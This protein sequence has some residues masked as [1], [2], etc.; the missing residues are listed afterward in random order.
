ML[1]FI[2]SLIM[3]AS[4]VGKLFEIYQKASN[5]YLLAFLL[6]KSSFAN[7]SYHNVLP[8]KKVKS[9]EDDTNDDVTAEEEKFPSS[10]TSL[11]MTNELTN[12]AQ[13]TEIVDRRLRL[14]VSVAKS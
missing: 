7:R 8:E 6:T 11:V 5:R 10:L 2:I 3:L 4:V 9:D 1:I 14:V 12:V 13:T